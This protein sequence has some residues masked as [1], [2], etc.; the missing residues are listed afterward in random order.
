MHFRLA[1]FGLGLVAVAAAVGGCG[2]DGANPTPDSS[3]DT[4]GNLSS[5]VAPLPASSS[6]QLITINGA[7]TLVPPLD[8]PV[9]AGT[10]LSVIAA[11]SNPLGP[12]ESDD[13]FAAMC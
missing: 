11:G 9:A 5:A 7:E 10:P 1:S 6:S 13:T 3:V 12:L 2:G 8:A 4:T